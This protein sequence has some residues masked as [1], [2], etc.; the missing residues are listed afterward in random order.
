MGPGK[1]GPGRLGPEIVRVRQIG[2][3]KNLDVA[4]WFPEIFLAENWSQENFCCSKLGPWKFWGGKSGPSQIG[5]IRPYNKTS[6][7]NISLGMAKDNTFVK[8]F[9]AKNRLESSDPH[10]RFSIAR[11]RTTA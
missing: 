7:D 4:N 10:V 5:L 1:L 9:A 3:Q 6:R 11:Q 8:Q 2:L